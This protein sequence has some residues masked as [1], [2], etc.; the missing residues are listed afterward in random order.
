VGGTIFAI[1]FLAAL[2]A[3]VCDFLDEHYPLH[4]PSERS[5]QPALLDDPNDYH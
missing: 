1:A 3:R 2:G 4:D 5:E